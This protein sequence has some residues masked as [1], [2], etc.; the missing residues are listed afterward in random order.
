MRATGSG[1]S[2]LLLLDVITILK[3]FRVPYA[4]IG[5]FAASFHGVVRASL[6]ADAIISLRSS[7]ADAEVLLDALHKAG[8][9]SRYR[10]GE[11]RDPVGGVI[12]IEDRFH[13][14][15]VSYDRIDMTLLKALVKPYGTATLHQLD[16]VL[17]AR[18]PNPKT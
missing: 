13:N 2:A 10:T 3:R 18:H 5:A 11:A 9:K 4:I 17:R 14:Q 7:Q 12:A 15:R 8:V 1:Q 6:D 16:S